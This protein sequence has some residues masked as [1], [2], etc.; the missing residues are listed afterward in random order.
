MSCLVV[1]VGVAEGFTADE[2][3][4]DGVCAKPPVRNKPP[5]NAGKRERTI[6][7]ISSMLPGNGAEGNIAAEMRT[8]EL[9]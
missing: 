8:F 7:L 3:E 9:N 2:G 5:I 4:T 1:G 6:G